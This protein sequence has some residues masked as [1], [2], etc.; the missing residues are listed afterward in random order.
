MGRESDQRSATGD[1]VERAAARR[2]RAWLGE[3]GAGAA[4][5]DLAPAVREQRAWNALRWWA[6]W[7]SG[8]NG[9]LHPWTPA[10]TDAVLGSPEGVRAIVERLVGEQFWSPRGHEDPRHGAWRGKHHRGP[11]FDEGMSGKAIAMLMLAAI[12]RGGGDL[13]RGN[14][15]APVA[16]SG[17]ARFLPWKTRRTPM[18]ALAAAIRC[19]ELAQF[20]WDDPRRGGSGLGGMLPQSPGWRLTGEDAP[21][22]PSIAGHATM[23]DGATST[24]MEGLLVVWEALPAWRPR[25]GSM[26]NRCG[27]GVSDVMARSGGHVAEQMG[28]WGE[29]VW[30]RPRLEPPAASSRALAYALGDLCR[31][32]ALR[33]EDGDTASVI[34]IAMDTLDAMRSDAGLGGDVWPRW[35]DPARRAPVWAHLALDGCATSDPAMA[36]WPSGEG[37]HDRSPGPAIAR[38][39]AYLAAVSGREAA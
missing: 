22:F 35:W 17:A 33:G 11:T 3:R 15:P 9:P 37:E 23:N 36:A 10:Q 25:I 12:V 1:Q 20:L 5:D 18:A 13:A 14:T 30:G 21:D 4:E 19:V 34:R 38:A 29:P 28:L 27:L 2:V 7:S 6:R 26:I 16:A 24:T 31:R 32:H 8:E 39:K